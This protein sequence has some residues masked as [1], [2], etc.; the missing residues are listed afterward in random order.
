MCCCAILCACSNTPNSTPFPP[1]SEA[2]QNAEQR[3]AASDDPNMQTTGD[4]TNAGDLA[5]NDAEPDAANPVPIEIPQETAKPCQTGEVHENGACCGETPYPADTASQWVC[6]GDFLR[7][8]QPEGCTLNTVTYPTF[9]E[10]HPKGVFCGESTAPQNMH[11]FVCTGDINLRLYMLEADIQTDGTQPKLGLWRFT[12]FSRERLDISPM[13]EYWKCE[14]AECDCHGVT[15]AQSDICMNTKVLGKFRFM[16]FINE[17]DND[18]TGMIYPAKSDRYGY[19]CNGGRWVCVGKDC[20]CPTK[21]KEGMPVYKTIHL[22]DICDMKPIAQA[23][24]ITMP[25][26]MNPEH[27]TKCQNGKCLCTM[28]DEDE[29]SNEVKPLFGNPNCYCGKVIIGPSGNGGQGGC[30]LAHEEYFTVY[31]LKDVADFSKEALDPNSEL[32][33]KEINWTVDESGCEEEENNDTSDDDAND[34][35]DD[36]DDDS[37]DT[38]PTNASDTKTDTA[39]PSSDGADANEKSA[40][41]PDVVTET[42]AK[43]EDKEIDIKEDIRLW[44]DDKYKICLDYKGCPCS[45][46]RCPMSTVCVDGQCIDPLTR[47]KVK[48]GDFISTIQCAD[49]ATCSC[50]ENPCGKNEW[51][52]AGKCYSELFA[53]IYQDKRLLYNPFGALYRSKYG[54]ESYK[55]NYHIRIFEQYESHELIDYDLRRVS[56]NILAQMKVGY[57]YTDYLYHHLECCGGAYIGTMNDLRCVRAMGCPCGSTT[58]QMG[59]ICKDDQCLYDSH[60]LNMMCYGNSEDRSSFHVDDGSG[61]YVDDLYFKKYNSYEA[62]FDEPAFDALRVDDMG[63]CL[64]NRTILKPEILNNHREQYVCDD[65]GWVC[66]ETQ[67]CTCGNAT[68]D[69]KA[70]CLKPGWCTDPLAIYNNIGWGKESRKAH[71]CASG[72]LDNNDDCCTSGTLNKEGYCC[73]SGVLSQSGYCCP[74]DFVNDAGQ[75]ACLIDAKGECCASGAFDK[76]DICCPNGECKSVAQK[77]QHQFDITTTSVLCKHGKQ[78]ILGEYGECC[79]GVLLDDGGCCASGLI[80]DSGHCCESG[81]FDEDGRCCKVGSVLDKHGYCCDSGTLDKEGVCCPY[82][83]E[84]GVCLCESGVR[85]SSGRCCP[86][87]YAEISGNEKKCTCVLL[88]K[89][90][91]CCESGVLSKSGYC[92]PVDDVNPKTGKCRHFIDK[93]GDRYNKKNVYTNNG[94]LCESGV[95]IDDGNLCCKSKD[96][97]NGMCSCASGVYVR[98]W[99]RAECCESGIID[100][101][102]NCCPTGVLSENGICCPKKHVG[103]N[104]QCLCL[105]ERESNTCARSV[106][107][108][109]DENCDSGILSVTRRCCKYAKDKF[110]NCCDAK[111]VDPNGYCSGYQ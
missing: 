21:I 25:D 74:K 33:I 100:K 63:N 95:V 70:I 81:K 38:V 16:S 19:D 103:S 9:A 66:T 12:G 71:E 40:P 87:G 99:Y 101:Y 88:D 43:Q 13:R 8:L 108:D 34:T 57:G 37:D 77:E 68:C 78:G 32:Y 20:D 92:C 106:L 96:V 69:Y 4:D 42:A 111:G 80:A 39:S 44:Y 110:G 46:S 84:N 64:C 76:N 109:S 82:G 15:I 27:A 23:L 50:T 49:P 86:K 36:D 5:K 85:H 97:K 10:I 93:R 41:T 89:G 90:G 17:D 53:V 54:Y 7:C 73:N 62:T 65:Y 18:C 98:D 3:Q 83:V 28:D 107:D 105:I 47:Q 56:N 72:V 1:D 31:C 60:Y 55:D 104:G 61:F 94:Y 22:G 11:G 29:Y 14:Q 58:C 75:C 30:Y 59:G 51:C 26:N 48:T 79:E 91:A 35:S 2:A 102:M 24:K 45:D 52:V 67:G 6:F